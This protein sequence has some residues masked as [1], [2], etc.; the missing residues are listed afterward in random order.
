MK[1]QTHLFCEKRNRGF[2]L[3]E[4]LVVIAII[5]I[6]T[7]IILVGLDSSRKM[8]RD[9]KRVADVNNIAL[10]LELYYNKNRSYPKNINWPDN[11]HTK[12]VPDFL[13]TEPKDP[14]GNSYMYC[15]ISDDANAYHLG[16]KLE[17]TGSSALKDDKDDNTLGENCSGGGQGFNGTI[18]D[19]Y[20]LVPAF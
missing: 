20:D 14:N 11:T 16:T 3:I 18:A 1:K 5:G 4:L 7:G 9:T 6:L 19:I 2:T 10:A 8:G 15:Q 12:L 17:N 13:A